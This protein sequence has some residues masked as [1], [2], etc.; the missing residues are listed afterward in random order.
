MVFILIDA[1]KFTDKKKQEHAEIWIRETDKKLKGKEANAIDIL[2]RFMNRHNELNKRKKCEMYL[3]KVRNK[4]LLFRKHFEDKVDNMT[5]ESKKNLDKYLERSRV[6][7]RNMRKRHPGLK[8]LTKKEHIYN[9]MALR[10]E[11]Q[12]L[13]IPDDSSKKWEYTKT[14]NQI[15]NGLDKSKSFEENIRK[16]YPQLRHLTF[17]EHLYNAVFLYINDKLFFVPNRDHSGWVYNNDSRES[18][19]ILK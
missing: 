9:A 14:N 13:F 18:T 6:Y 5:N 4:W 12:F 19:F 8:S 1:S 15:N 3:N 17:K 11:G 2:S 10:K 7:E 16:K